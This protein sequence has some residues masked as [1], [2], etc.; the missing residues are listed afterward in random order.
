MTDGEDDPF[1]EQAVDL[2]L[3]GDMPV[4]FVAFHSRPTAWS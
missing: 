4:E 1:G 3:A 2:D